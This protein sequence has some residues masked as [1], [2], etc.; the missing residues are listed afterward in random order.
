MDYSFDSATPHCIWYSL[1]AFLENR[2]PNPLRVP[3]CFLSRERLSHCRVLFALLKPSAFGSRANSGFLIAHAIRNLL[4][5]V[6]TVPQSLV[7][8]FYQGLRQKITLILTHRGQDAKS[9][10]SSLQSLPTTRPR[11]ECLSFPSALFPYGLSAH[12]IRKATIL[13]CLA[14]Y[15]QQGHRGYAKRTPF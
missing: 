2:L 11:R 5:P 8:A 6:A 12:R 15:C 4:F 10:L 7:D 9:F 14:H 1:L 3:E 13:P